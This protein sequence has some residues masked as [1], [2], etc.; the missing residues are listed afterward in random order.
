MTR[1][2][3]LGAAGYVAPRHMQAI[4]ETGGEL[5]AACDPHDSVGVLDRY[6]PQC[7]Y[8]PEVERFERYLDKLRRNG[9]GVDYVSICTPNWLHDA[10]VR[11]ALRNGADA[12][13][14]KPVALKPRNV[15]AL[16]AIEQETGRRVHPV[17]QLRCAPTL[18]AAR[19]QYADA[20]P[21]QVSA[22]YTAPR[23]RWY[24]HSWKGHPGKSGGP[25]MNIGVHVVDLLMWIFGDSIGPC[26]GTIQDNGKS[27]VLSIELE[28]ARV[29]MILSLDGTAKPIRQIRIDAGTS[30]HVLD[31][32]EL[33]G[34]LHT[35]AYRAVLRGDGPTLAD[36]A[37]SIE[38]IANV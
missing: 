4:A 5:V 6:F 13:C 7:H 2:A 37:K 11:L 10:H 24:E 27:V 22:I 29:A 12:I 18:I 16:M 15:E 35:E 8:F 17:L 21:R 30:L 33:I 20:P 9:E 19:D 31:L 1:Y 38:L 34:E 28:R 36:A 26:T 25:L 14:E 23:G 32:T 3:L